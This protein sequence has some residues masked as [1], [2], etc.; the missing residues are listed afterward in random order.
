M[1]ELRKEMIENGI[2]YTLIGDYYFPDF[3]DPD[4]ISSYGRWSDLHKQYLHECHPGVYLELLTSDRLVSYLKEFNDQAEAHYQRIIRQM[5][6]SDGVNEHLKEQDQLGWVQRMN[7]IA[8]RA[9]EIVL[10]ELMN[11]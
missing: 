11:R 6:D 8:A 7:G 2:H 10:D 9:R 5:A 1:S 4:E 3:S